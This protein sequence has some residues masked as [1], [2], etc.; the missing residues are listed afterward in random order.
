MKE[1][2]ETSPFFSSAFVTKPLAGSNFSF[3]VRRAAKTSDFSVSCKLA[4][5]KTNEQM[6]A[7]YI[8]IKS[9]FSAVQN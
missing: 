3:P 6:I 5:I 2:E 1:Q 7:E 4:L 9:I 8:R